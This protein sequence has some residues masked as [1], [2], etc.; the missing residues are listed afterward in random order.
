MASKIGL[1]EL[2]RDMMTADLQL[3]EKESLLKNR[4]FKINNNDE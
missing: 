4:G 1:D 3:F 2:V